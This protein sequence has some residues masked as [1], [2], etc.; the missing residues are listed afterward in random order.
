MTTKVMLRLAFLFVVVVSM[1]HI[2]NVV[3]GSLNAR[4]KEMAVLMAIGM[5]RWQIRK[6]VLWEHALYGIIGGILGAAISA[7]LLE[8]LLMLLS[9]ATKIRFVLPWDYMWVGFCSAIVVSM[10][11]AL[12]ATGNVAKT[13]IVKEISA[14]D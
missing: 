10:A 2:Y 14:N 6:S 1:L 3:R 11:V 13:G 8:R 7:V 12:Y 9:G 4:E 5:K